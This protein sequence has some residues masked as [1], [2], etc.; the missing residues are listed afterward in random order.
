[1]QAIKRYY[2]KLLKHSYLNKMKNIVRILTVI[3]F[4]ACINFAANAQP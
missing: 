1:M 4:I 3:A 2:K